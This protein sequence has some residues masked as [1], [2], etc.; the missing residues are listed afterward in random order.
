MA[1]HSPLNVLPQL[2]SVQQLLR[3]ATIPPETGG[4]NDKSNKKALKK[5]LIA[6]TFATDYGTF[7]CST[8]STTG[9]PYQDCINTIA[10]FC[11]DKSPLFSGWS[12]CHSK[13]LT[14]RN[15]LNANWKNYINSCAKFAGGSPTSVACSDATYRINTQEV[16]YFFS[17]GVLQTA[18]IPVTLTRSAAYIWDT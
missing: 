5:R 1:D 7:T 13:V 10:A 11:Q 9:S 16:Y 15:V 17:G 18:Y 14:V 6:A 8:N 4:K 12:N 2:A 3:L